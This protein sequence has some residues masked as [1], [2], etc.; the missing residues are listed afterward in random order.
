MSE[1]TTYYFPKELWYAIKSFEHQI[2]YPI[3]EQKKA[4]KLMKYH[5]S[6]PY[7]LSL[8]DHKSDEKHLI[9][10]KNNHSDL[11]NIYTDST[12]RDLV[13]KINENIRKA[14]N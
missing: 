7:L 3:K 10:F 2:L 12:I 1:K 9:F 14:Y 13:Q 6:M 8:H 4:L 5:I 11:W